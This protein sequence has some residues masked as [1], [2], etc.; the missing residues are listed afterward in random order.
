TKTVPLEERGGSWQA[1][2]WAK[3]AFRP[4]HAGQYRLRVT[5]QDAGGRTAESEFH[6]YVTGADQLAWEYRN[7]AQV[8][9]VPDKKE[10]QPGETA[11]VLLKSPISGDAMVTIE[12]GGKILRTMRTRLEGNAPALEIPLT[13]A[14]APNVFV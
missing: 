11:R 7:P 13:A 10:Y 8:D 9:M 3:T 1:L 2:E 4:T 14:D 6:L 12:R 5:A